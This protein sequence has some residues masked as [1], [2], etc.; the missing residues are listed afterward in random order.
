MSSKADELRSRLPKLA[1]EMHW[2][3]AFAL[4]KIRELIFIADNMGQEPVQL[5]WKKGLTDALWQLRAAQDAQMRFDAWAKEVLAQEIDAC[6]LT[7]EERASV[8]GPPR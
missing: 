3:V 6:G 5:A 1:G 2:G 8:F 7:A 4:N